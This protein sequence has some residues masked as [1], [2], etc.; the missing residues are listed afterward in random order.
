MMCKKPLITL[1]LISG[2]A[3]LAACGG[4]GGGKSTPPLN[5]G[6]GGSNT[7]DSYTWKMGEFTPYNEL[8]RK[9]AANGS[10][11]ELVE[12]LWQRSYSND[13]YL[14]Y[15]EIPD[16]D[17]APYSVLDY[18]DTLITS[19]RTPSGKLKDQ[20]HFTMS[21][22]EWNKLTSS[23]ESV[24]YGFNIAITQGV[25]VERTITVT[26]SEPDSPAMAAN[27]I[28]G[29]KILEIDGVSVADAND[30]A[31][32]D[33]LNHGLFPEANGQETKFLVRDLGAEQTREVTLAA[34]TI[35]SDPVPIVNTFDAGSSKVGYLVF[36]DHIATAEKGLY[37]AF[38]EL[39]AQD[40]DELIIDFRYNGGGYLAIASELG[41]MVGGQQTQGKVFEKTIFND[42][43]PTR[44]PV[45]GRTLQ[46]TPFYSETVGL[47]STV[48]S[49]GLELPT[50]SL[51]RV[52][53]L[54][55][56]GTC[57]ASEAFINGMRGIDVEVIQIGSTTCGKPYGFYA[58]DNCDTTYFTVQ[59]KGENHQG[60]GDYADGFSPST[61]PMLDTEIQGCPVADDLSKPL[62]DV[63]E[64][65][66]SSAIYYLEH[67]SC[68]EVNASQSLMR[69][70][71]PSRDIIGSEFV[72]QDMRARTRFSS[73]R[74]LTK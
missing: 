53:V 5:L 7:N 21:T 24:G 19:E 67:G 3:T 58:T 1:L 9:C 10:G 74:I 63:S 61:N 32:I 31:S 69:V 50:V 44:N 70:Q 49:A 37:D 11:S 22:D 16:Q 6:N 40:I 25:D 47:K 55:S 17:P 23:G 38:T 45:T 33:V 71:A 14:W 43:Y 41:Y 4:G 56:A 36:N 42:K 27:V 2:L 73:N 35:V 34:Q 59:F 54:T 64:G 57:S 8:A 48:I 62:G 68:P 66:L 72:V 29:A 13:T 20:F 30:Q 12:K 60:F 28:R 52:F 26:Y 18:F 15:D 46:P 65:M 51:S 39:A